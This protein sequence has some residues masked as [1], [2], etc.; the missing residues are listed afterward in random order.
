MKKAITMLIVP[1]FALGA[2]SKSPDQIGVPTNDQS[3]YSQDGSYSQSKLYDTYTAAKSNGYNGSFEDWQALVKLHE[4]NP[5]QATQ[6]AQSSG[7]SGSSAVMGA[8]A[9]AGATALAMQAMNNNA[10]RSSSNYS[11]SRPSTSYSNSTASRSTA[12]VSRGGF[13]GAVSSGG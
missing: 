8:I 10:N 13:G 3:V 7:F 6:Q 4:T 9:G 11:N 12:S 1:A 2:C 5:E